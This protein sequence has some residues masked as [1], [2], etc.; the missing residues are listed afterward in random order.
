V[1]TKSQV[2]SVILTDACEASLPNSREN[3]FVVDLGLTWV[4]QISLVALCLVANV[5]C[6]VVDVLLRCG[7]AGCGDTLVSCFVGHCG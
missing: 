2:V 5:L 6:G 4:A 7:V 1:S 3:G